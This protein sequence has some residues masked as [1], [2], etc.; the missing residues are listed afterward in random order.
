MEAINF[1]AKIIKIIKKEVLVFS[2]WSVLII[3]LLLIILLLVSL[4]YSNSMFTLTLGTR[5]YAS[6]SGA[7]AILNMI[8]CY[9][10]DGQWSL[11]AFIEYFLPRFIKNDSI[12]AII[13]HITLVICSSLLLVNFVYGIWNL[14]HKGILSIFQRSHT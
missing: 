13:Y 9:W 2:T 12:R 8:P 4:G 6:L 1:V 7:L 10:L 14:R 3:W 5:Y 11:L